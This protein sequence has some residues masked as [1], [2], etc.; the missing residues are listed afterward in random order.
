MTM[1]AYIAS[2]SRSWRRFLD[3][4]TEGLYAHAADCRDPA[5]RYRWQD[6]S[7]RRYEDLTRK[8]VELAE[9]RERC[10]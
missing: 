1:D 6:E 7:K 5:Y 9:Q 2:R 8:W 3:V 4:G 10:A